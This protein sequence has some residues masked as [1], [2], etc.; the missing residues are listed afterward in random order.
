MNEE[1]RNDEYEEAIS[2]FYEGKGVSSVI[3]F[4]VDAKMADDIAEKL[5]KYDNIED[6]FLV[7]GEIDLIAKARFQDYDNMKKF[8]VHE[9]SNL[10]GVEDLQSK[11]IITTYKERF[12][13]IE[14]EELED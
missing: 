8:L 13:A 10:D 5:A 1:K 2:N 3:F 4:K 6:L 7:T 14:S 9:A 11:M 12:E